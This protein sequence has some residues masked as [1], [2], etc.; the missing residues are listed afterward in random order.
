M[1]TT[2]LAAVW[3]SAWHSPRYLAAGRTIALVGADHPVL[4]AGNTAPIGDARHNLIENA[5]AK[6]GPGTEVVVDIGAEG[7]RWPFWTVDQAFRSMI[8]R[9]SLIVSGVAR[10]GQ[11]K[12]RGLDWRSSWRSSGARREYRGK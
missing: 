12:G 2:N 6:P 3:E 10:G 4:N 9:A 5:L 1:L 7:A 11:P 8:G